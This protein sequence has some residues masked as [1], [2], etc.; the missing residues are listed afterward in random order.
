MSR[1]KLLYAAFTDGQLRGD[2]D[3]FAKKFVSKVVWSSCLLGLLGVVMSGYG[4]YGNLVVKSSCEHDANFFE[5]M[6]HACVPAGATEEDLAGMQT[7]NSI[8]LATAIS[9]IIG[10]GLVQSSISDVK[11]QSFGSAK[12]KVAAAVMFL[13]VKVVVSAA[14]VFS[15]GRISF[16]PVLLVLLKVALVA[17]AVAWWQVIGIAQGRASLEGT[18]PGLVG[19]ERSGEEVGAYGATGAYRPVPDQVTPDQVNQ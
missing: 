12:V 7:A 19:E 15:S 2:P 1:I 18:L 6:T 4:L 5:K 13:L 8:G 11:A 3:A 17:F 9:L 14:Q 16:L 10:G